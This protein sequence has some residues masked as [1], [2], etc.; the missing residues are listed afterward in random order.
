V[1]VTDGFESSGKYEEGYTAS[2][3]TGVL[4]FSVVFVLVS[5]IGGIFYDL[6]RVINEPL[7]HFDNGGGIVVLPPL[8]PHLNFDLFLSHAQDLG[9]DQVAAIK[10]AL[11]KLLRLS[12]RNGISKRATRSRERGGVWCKGAGRSLRERRKSQWGHPPWTSRTSP[13]RAPTI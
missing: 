2:S 4:I 6:R 3:I 13:Y 1:K 12:L 5:G 11:E 10:Y 8:A 9:Q 7:F